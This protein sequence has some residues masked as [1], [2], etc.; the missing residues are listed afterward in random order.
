M[1]SKNR[2][3]QYTDI[4]RVKVVPPYLRA[5]ET[6]VNDLGLPEK[7]YYTTADVCKLLGISPD[8]FRYRMK[9]GYY[10]DVERVGGKRRFNEEE[11]REIIQRDKTAPLKREL[12]TVSARSYLMVNEYLKP[13]SLNLTLNLIIFVVK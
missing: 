8:T 6:P 12:I 3:P 7:D 9:Q 11:I 2:N 10:P 1:V 13:K 4:L 5:L